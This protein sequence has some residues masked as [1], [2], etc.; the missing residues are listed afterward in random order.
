MARNE[1]GVTLASLA[2]YIIVSIVVLASLAFLN[3]NVISQI[4]H[5]SNDSEETNELLRAEA[6]LIKDIK[7]ANRVLEFSEQYLRLDNDVEYT[8]RYRA[9][10]KQRNQTY[11]VYELYRGDI[12][13]TD[14]MSGISFDYGITYGDAS[15]KQIVE[16]EWVIVKIYDSN[17][18]GDDLCI[19]VGKGY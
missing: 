5:L 19:K 11:D 7:N 8:I 17:H 3:V 2:I 12:L 14:K 15:N 9:N 10:E 1:R 6:Y 16:D 13:V 4:A 18:V